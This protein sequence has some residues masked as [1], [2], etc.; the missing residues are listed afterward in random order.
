LLIGHFDL[1]HAD[2]SLLFRNSLLLSVFIRETTPITA[3]L[4]AAQPDP[5]LN[6][7][8][9]RQRGMSATVTRRLSEATVGTL[10]V[11]VINSQGVQNAVN[12]AIVAPDFG[13][14]SY[15]ATLTRTISPQTTA[16]VTL[17]MLTFSSNATV[18]ARER[19]MIFTLNHTFR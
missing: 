8:S 15:R 11:D 1:W 2:G 17:R 16:A 7:A 14:R 18:G 5:F 4:S 9:I 3:S 19:A 10:N 13:Q 12:P 6:V